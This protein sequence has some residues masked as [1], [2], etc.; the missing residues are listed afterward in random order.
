MQAATKD[1]VFDA[2]EAVDT[3]LY[4][5][6]F[7][8]TAIR[9]SAKLR[10]AEKAINRGE[11]YPGDIPGRLR[12]DFAHIKDRFD[13]AAVNDFDESLSQAAYHLEQ[14][15]PDNWLK[16][17]EI[18]LGSGGKLKLARKPPIRGLEKDLVEPVAKNP[19]AKSVAKTKR[20]GVDAAIYAAIKRHPNKTYWTVR[21]MHEATGYSLSHICEA[22]AWDEVKRI[23]KEAATI[24]LVEHYGNKVVDCQDFKEKSRIVS[25]VTRNSGKRRGRTGAKVYYNNDGESMANQHAIE[26]LD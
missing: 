12:E 13:S 11:T 7:L 18:I 14:E 22:D 15:E 9:A 21:E 6:R 8:G 26:G 4:K 24:H 17:A 5:V 3:F 2:D 16:A 1:W 20:L 23:M 19:R 25:R 10:K